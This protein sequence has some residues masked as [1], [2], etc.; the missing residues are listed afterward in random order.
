M[1]PL[2]QHAICKDL[3]KITNKANELMELIIN[4]DEKRVLSEH[5]KMN[6]KE[7]YLG[8]VKAHTFA[9]I[10]YD[11]IVEGDDNE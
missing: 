10:V 9:I 2:M 1:D 8:A 11:E 7:A 6:L 4:L 3:D 5:T